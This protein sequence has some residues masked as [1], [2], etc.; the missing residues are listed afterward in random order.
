MKTRRD[1]I[2]QLAG[3]ALVAS[4]AKSYANILGANDRLNVAVMGTRSRGQS[5]LGDLIKSSSSNVTH[6]C[7]VDREILESTLAYVS[8]LD[9]P[10]PKSHVDIRHVLDDPDLDALV[11]AAPDHWHATATIMGLQAGK[12]VYLEK[13]CGYDPYEGELLE[14]AQKKYDRVVQMGNQQRSSPESIELMQA[15]RSGDIGDPYHATCWYSNNRQ[16][17]GNGKIV[18]VP[19]RLD[20]DLWQGPAPRRAYADNLV[21]YNWHWFWHWGTGELCNNAAHELDIARWALNLSFP[22]KVTVDGRRRFFVDDD[23]E[24]YDT[25]FA[26]YEFEGDRSITWEGHSCNK[27]L[28]WGRSRGTMIYGTKGSVLVDRAGFTMFDLDGVVTREMI[29]VT[30]SAD[31]A[32]LVGGGPLTALH[33][34]NFLNTV[35]GKS[36]TQHS[37]IDEGHKS[38]L[39]CHLGNIAY[40]TQS[41]LNCDPSNGHIRRNREARR[42]WGREYEPGWDLKI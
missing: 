7:D 33:V 3:A 35:N 10:R 2:R 39:L 1:F 24:M 42:L 6:V 36:S 17:I 34:D 37:P 19:E 14:K 30:E 22:N 40:R 23:W 32:D 4:S 16:S 8:S 29:S 27:V 38:T 26:R 41:V 28:K 25:M 20:W 13:P 21:P 31:S 11:V 9:A 18:T 5:L 12:H 15:I